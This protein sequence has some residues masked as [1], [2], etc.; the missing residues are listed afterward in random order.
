MS[1]KINKNKKILF[2]GLV[3]F[4]ILILIIIYMLF[5]KTRDIIK[6]NEKYLSVEY[7]EVLDYQKLIESVDPENAKIEYPD[8]EIK[9]VGT[10][11]LTFTYN[12]DGKKGTQTVDVVVKDTKLPKV[13]IKNEKTVEVMI[14]SEYDVFANI[15]EIENLSDEAKQNRQLVTDDEY[16]KYKK[17]IDE[18]NKLIGEREISNKDDIKESDIIK[19]CILYNSN[20]DISKEGNYNIKMLFV[21]ENYNIEEESWKVKVVPTGQIVNSGGTVSCKYPND[22]LQTNEAYTT[23]YSEV[24]IY[25][26]SKLVSLSKFIT[27]MTFNED[28]DTDDNVNSLVNA[29]NSKYESYKKYEGVTVEVIP[30]AT[31]VTTNIIV[32][33]SSY[34]LKNDPLNILE[35]KDSGKVK[36]ENVVNNLKDKATCELY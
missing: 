3:I 33:F 11:H 20:L 27:T 24:Y 2:T 14:N 19:N 15:S 21:D 26:E 12:V 7:G 23:D 9:E 31:N 32:D 4:L 16:K 30:S 1:L 29:I 6:F 13:K 34:D 22:S 18:Q 8:L 35:K 25:D 10:Y 36:I 28:Y 5:F 17:Q